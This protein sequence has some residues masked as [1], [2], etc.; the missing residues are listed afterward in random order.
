MTEMD[1]AEKFD[2]VIFQY[3]D[4]GKK[5][6][7]FLQAKHIQDVDRDKIT[8]MKLLSKAKKEPFKLRKYFISYIKIT[9]RDE[10][11]NGELK[12]FIICTN[13]G[14]DF[15]INK[16]AQREE[17]NKREQGRRWMAYFNKIE[18]EDKILNIGGQKYRFVDNTLDPDGRK[19]I[20]SELRLK[21]EEALKEETEKLE[22]KVK[23]LE[24]NIAK[25][26]NADNKKQEEKKLE[27]EKKLKE[28]LERIVK[29]RGLLVNKI[30]EFLNKLVLAV[31][32][33]NEVSL[34]E[35][36]KEEI[37][38]DFS[39]EAAELVNSRFLEKMLDWIKAKGG[40]FFRM[41]RVKLFLMS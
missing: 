37:K 19:D 30:E 35:R 24:K 26:K 38:K 31:N 13:T 1:A 10:F 25:E 18:D 33:P 5:I 22:G 41:S 29:S 17:K 3:E 15:G 2:D 32:Q 20:V 7:R 14:F 40:R 36:I 9:A 16:K 12:D 8:W 39:L 6:F 4:D 34:G 23:R 11:T 27:E 21:F 28:V